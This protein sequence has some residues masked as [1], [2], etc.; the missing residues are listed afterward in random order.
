M[1]MVE[2]DAPDQFYVQLREKGKG[3]NLTRL[4]KI[5]QYYIKWYF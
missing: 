1:Q 4:L 2:I 3:N 5:G